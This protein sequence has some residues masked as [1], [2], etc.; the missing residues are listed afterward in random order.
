MWR[1]KSSFGVRKT[2][3]IGWFGAIPGNPLPEGCWRFELWT[4]SSF[5]FAS[6]SRFLRSYTMRADEFIVISRCLSYK[7]GPYKLTYKAHDFHCHWTWIPYFLGIS[8][9]LSKPPYATGKSLRKLTKIEMAFYQKRKASFSSSPLSKF[10]SLIKAG[11]VFC[12]RASCGEK[13]RSHVKKPLQFKSN[14]RK[15]KDK[16]FFRRIWTPACFFCVKNE[17]CFIQIVRIHLYHPLSIIQSIGLL[18]LFYHV[19]T[20][21]KTFQNLR[22]YADKLADYAR[23]VIQARRV[24]EWKK[25]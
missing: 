11:R 12:H 15:M 23:K 5:G 17:S 14:L 3:I 8:F 16:S 9:K 20:T 25:N 19:L 13:R 2:L 7:I 4:M 24:P 6:W 21:F 1:K 10:K 22:N 18:E